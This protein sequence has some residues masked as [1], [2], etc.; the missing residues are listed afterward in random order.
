MNKLNLYPDVNMISRRVSCEYSLV[1]LHWAWRLEQHEAN[2][3]WS[4]TGKLPE[5]QTV[6]TVKSSLHAIS[7]VKAIRR[8]FQ[9][10]NESRRGCN[11]DHTGRVHP[12]SKVP[13]C[14]LFLKA[15]KGFR[16]IF[17]KE[18]RKWGRFTSP[19]IASRGEHQCLAWPY[20]L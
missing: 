3:R 8:S 5:R 7:T 11:A 1:F 15:L 4:E 18:V 17:V 9:L 19:D 20:N 12:T 14:P 16:Y 2:S 10:S 6:I 13:N